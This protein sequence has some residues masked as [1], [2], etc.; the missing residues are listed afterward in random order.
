M[1]RLLGV[2]LIIS[3]LVSATG[4]ESSFAAAGPQC[5]NFTFQDDAQQILDKYGYAE[6]LDVD[7]DGIACNELPRKPPQLIGTLSGRIASMDEHFRLIGVTE[8]EH[9]RLN[10]AGVVFEAPSANCNVDPIE[11]IESMF[12]PGNNIFFLSEASDPIRE[13]DDGY[14]LVGSAWLYGI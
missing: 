10:L 7:G 12:P 8:D 9:F 11:A 1:K 2:I 5:S 4:G 6:S 3:L 13:I 14:R